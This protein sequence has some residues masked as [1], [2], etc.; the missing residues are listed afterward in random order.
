M[1]Q[2]R[3][4]DVEQERYEAL[5][6][7][8]LRVAVAIA[9][10]LRAQRTKGEELKSLGWSRRFGKQVTTSVPSGDRREHNDSGK[11]HKRPLSKLYTM[12]PCHSPVPVK[13]AP[14]A[15]MRARLP[16]AHESFVRNMQCGI[17]LSRSRRI[18]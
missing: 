13:P 1:V 8:K 12:E 18:L 14:N 10:R 2:L 5:G 4:Y 16:W 15:H 7:D 11:I 3:L 9:E 6:I 17:H